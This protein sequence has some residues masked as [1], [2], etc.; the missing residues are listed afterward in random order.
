MHLVTLRSS[1]MTAKTERDKN[2]NRYRI[3]WELWIAFKEKP[4]SAVSVRPTNLLTYKE[5]KEKLGLNET[6]LSE[7]LKWHKEQKTI[8]EK[9]G[10]YGLWSR[11]RK[12]ALLGFAKAGGW[13]IGHKIRTGEIDR[14]TAN[15]WMRYLGREG[16]FKTEKEK[17]DFV[18][19][20]QKGERGEE[21][22]V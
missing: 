5:L 15:K 7:H 11:G 2:W 9:N 13:E 6:T 10:T 17:A 21:I 16:A 8:W 14:P 22:L 19:A 20:R 3:V 4:P 18:E 1:R 12:Y